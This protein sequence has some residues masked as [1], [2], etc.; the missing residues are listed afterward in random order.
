M[1]SESYEIKRY[2]SDLFPQVVN[3]LRFLWGDDYEENSN[4]FK[5]KHIDNPYIKNPLGIVALHKGDCVGFRGYFATK[6]RIGRNN[7]EFILLSPGDLVVHPDHRR[8]GL[9]LD[10]GYQAM[11]EYESIYKIFLSTTPSL[12]SFPGDLK[13]GFSPLVPLKSLVLF[14]RRK[15]P[16]DFVSLKLK[17]KIKRSMLYRK[18]QSLS[19]KK[20]GATSIKDKVVFGEAGSII[21]SDR[22]KPEEM[23]NIN[24]QHNRESHKIKLLQDKCF[25]QWRFWSKKNKYIFYYHKMEKKI[26]GYLVLGISQQNMRHGSVLDYAETDG[27]AL[28]NIF[29]F[30]I[31]T[32]HLDI[33][34]IISFGLNDNLLKLMKRLGL[35]RSVLSQARE[36]NEDGDVYLSVRPVKKKLSEEDWFVDGLDIR[37]YENW[38]IKPIC[39]DGA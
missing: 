12:A 15:S 23:Y 20:G 16:K 26:T 7:N 4:H 38:E 14:K 1:A 10:L 2:S 3:L 11:E 25:F 13:M 27:V 39:S 9:S 19:G 33:L 8:K 17:K 24:A 18:W 6:C 36:S 31:E 35:D 5:W 34:S 21:T 22:P 28:E 29:R 32:G 37:N 30:I